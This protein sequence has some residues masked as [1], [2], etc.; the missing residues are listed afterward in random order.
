MIYWSC[1]NSLARIHRYIN[2]H[3]PTQTNTLTPESDKLTPKS[4]FQKSSGRKSSSCMGKIR[5]TYLPSSF[6]V[7]TPNYDSRTLSELYSPLN[8]FMVTSPSEN[9]IVPSCRKKIPS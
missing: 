5:A 4:G 2:N 6:V 1:M 3:P 8:P 7:I 9:L